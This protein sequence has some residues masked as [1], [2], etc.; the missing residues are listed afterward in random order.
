MDQPSV[1]FALA[2]V[3]L[4]AVR[5]FSTIDSTNEEAKRWIEAGARHLSLVVADEQTAGRGRAGR[6]WVTPA[7]TGL[8][9]SLV[10]LSPPIKPGSLS[11]L[12]GLGAVA[13]GQA[14]ESKY[15]LPAQVK[16]PNDV[17]LEGRK[18]GGVLVEAHWDGDALRS[19]IMGI[20]IN[21]APESISASNLLTEGL[22]F[23]ATCVA[24]VL[25]RSLDRSEF[26]RIILLE[27]L[28]WLPR[29]SGPEFILEWEARLAYRNQWVELSAGSNLAGA[30]DRPDV[31][32][33]LAG[34]L[35]GLA[36]DGSL[37]LSTSSGRLV[38]V[39]IGDLHLRPVMAGEPSLPKG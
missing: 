4:S 34:K 32:E 16:W 20:G 3:G 19:V 2:D 6:R 13:V 10:L 24:N 37:Q 25:G 27:L 22:S 12:A 15:G 1:E 30:A 23:P 29:L 5:F 33:P 7:G 36:Q 35:I 21:I 11:R 28:S 26:L 18:V 39:A 38:T 8:A 9:F 14:L 17:L 31:A